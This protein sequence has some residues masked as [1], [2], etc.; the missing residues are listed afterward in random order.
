MGAGVIVIGTAAVIGDV[1][2]HVGVV[3]VV[4]AI[5]GEGARRIALAH[6]EGDDVGVI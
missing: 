3:L 4:V 1:A 2:A 5:E 6:G